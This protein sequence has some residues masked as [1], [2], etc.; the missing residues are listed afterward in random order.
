MLLARSIEVSQQILQRL[1][2][3]ALTKTYSRRGQITITKGGFGS[4]YLARS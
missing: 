1:N 4:K 3:G 2:P